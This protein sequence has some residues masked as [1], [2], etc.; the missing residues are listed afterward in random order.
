MNKAIKK[1]KEWNPSI[2]VGGEL[3][4]ALGRSKETCWFMMRGIADQY[5]N[6]TL[7]VETPYKTTTPT[8]L[9][10]NMEP[11][12]D[13]IVTVMIGRNIYIGSETDIETYLAGME[14]YLN[15]H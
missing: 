15:A 10:K 9:L 8:A 14:E 6:G 3:F 2:A 5:K 7:E 1:N 12:I 13:V 4:A 11:K